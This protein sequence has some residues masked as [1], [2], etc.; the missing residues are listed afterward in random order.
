M[1]N[2]RY[3]TARHR[4]DTV[5]VLSQPQGR[6]ET[7]IIATLD[8][9]NDMEDIVSKHCFTQPENL[10]EERI[11]AYAL[12]LIRL[13]ECAS[14]TGI[15]RLVNAC[16]ALAVTVSRLIDDRDCA[17]YKKCETLARFIVHAKAMIQMSADSAES[18]TQPAP[19]IC[20]ISGQESV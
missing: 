19:N 12:A 4:I 13:R 17:C 11:I 9:L 10:T 15:Q 6:P 2:M 7:G 1:R 18:Y 14:A 3:L 16:D 5:K 8:A 20:T